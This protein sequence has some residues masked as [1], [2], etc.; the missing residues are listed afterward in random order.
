VRNAGLDHD[1]GPGVQRYAPDSTAQRTVSVGIPAIGVV[2]EA[3]SPGLKHRTDVRHYLVEPLI[4]RARPRLAEQVVQV[5]I[6]GLIRH[7]LRVFPVS[8]QLVPLAD[9][10]RQ[11]SAYRDR[12]NGECVRQTHDLLRTRPLPSHSDGV[13]SLRQQTV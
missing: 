12:I 10:S 9:F 7:K 13:L 6:P 11:S 8:M 5:L 4:F 2:A 1:L 3:P